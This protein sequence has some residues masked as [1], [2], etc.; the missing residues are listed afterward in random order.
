MFSLPE[1]WFADPN[2]PDLR[3]AHGGPRTRS[4]VAIAFGAEALLAPIAS[5]FSGSH[6]GS[7]DW[8]DLVHTART[9]TGVRSDT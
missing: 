1:W 6:L 4:T 9:G 5:R 8:F 2:L 7:E 3:G